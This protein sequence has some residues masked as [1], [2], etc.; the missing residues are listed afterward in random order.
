VDFKAGTDLWL[1]LCW[2]DCGLMVSVF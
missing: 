1:N 2:L